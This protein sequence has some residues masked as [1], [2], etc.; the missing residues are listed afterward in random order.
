MLLANQKL[1][2]SPLQSCDE[3]A[4]RAQRTW[5]LLYVLI[6]IWVFFG[7]FHWFQG[8][9]EAVRVCVVELLVFVAIPIF[10]TQIKK[11]RADHS[12]VPDLQCCWNLS[13]FNL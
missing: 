7:G 8:N 3:Q 10:S 4:L 2:D 6:A 5:L 9:V 1:L 12:L 11:L 13:N